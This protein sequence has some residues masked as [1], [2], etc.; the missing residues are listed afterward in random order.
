MTSAH[1]A[2]CW[3]AILD[4]SPRQVVVEIDGVQVYPQPKRKQPKQS[5]V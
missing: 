2:Y 1:A 3:I 5:D 4:M